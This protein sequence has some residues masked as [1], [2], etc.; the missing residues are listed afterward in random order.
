MRNNIAEKFSLLATGVAFD[1]NLT[2]VRSGPVWQRDAIPVIDPLA[3]FVTYQ[4]SLGIFDFRLKEG[5]PAIGA[6]SA[7]D[8]PEFDILSVPRN[9]LQ[10]DIG[11]YAY[12][13]EVE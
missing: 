3:T 8:A 5:S 13:V 12:T 11:A 7:L 9:P 2:F 4:P 6:G 1:H 10:I